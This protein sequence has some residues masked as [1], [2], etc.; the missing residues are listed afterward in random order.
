MSTLKKRREQ[1][2]RARQHEIMEDQQRGRQD[3]IASGQMAPNPGDPN[4][5]VVGG[6]AEIRV[7][8]AAERDARREAERSQPQMPAPAFTPGTYPQAPP[9][10]P[11]PAPA[12][13]SRAG[14]TSRVVQKGETSVA[15]RARPQSTV[16]GG[17]AVPGAQ[18]STR[19]D[20]QST[21]VVSKTQQKTS[22]ARIVEEQDT[23]VLGARVVRRSQNAYASTQPT[24]QP[25]PPGGPVIP[26][27]MPGASAGMVPAPM[28]MPGMPGMM[29]QAMPAMSPGQAGSPIPQSAQAPQAQPSVAPPADLTVI[30]TLFERPAFLRAQLQSI[31]E[32]TTRPAQIVA[33]VNQGTLPQDDAA[34]MAMP[35]LTLIR[36]NVNFGPWLRFT[37]AR[38]IVSTKYV[39]FLDDDAI[40]GPQWLEQAIARLEQSDGESFCIAAAGEVYTEDSRESLVL[41]GPEEPE[42]V[43]E[44]IEVDVGRL[45]WVMHRQNLAAFDTIPRPLDQRIGWR[46][47][48]AASLQVAAGVLTL[49]LPYGEDPSTWGVRQGPTNDR[50]FTEGLPNNVRDATYAHYRSVGWVPFEADTAFEPVDDDDVASRRATVGAEADV[51]GADAEESDD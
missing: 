23:Q 8:S 51:E 14:S 41:V 21:R 20:K 7:V 10:Q 42:E 9:P 16:R 35:G 24:A 15:R 1:R 25:V 17:A 5:L 37:L 11:A 2:A 40:L 22:T 27:M 30:L 31:L 26:G 32:Q 33:I 38:E 4:G 28:Q 6:N 44:E 34:L 46:M 13:T 29:P 18:G 43:S 45:A 3:A 49:M 48:L 12:P 36:A 47:H 39:C 50:A 19:R